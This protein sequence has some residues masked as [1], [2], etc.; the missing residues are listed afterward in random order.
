VTG[1]GLSETVIRWAATS[2]GL[3]SMTLTAAQSWAEEWVG[4]AVRTLSVFAVVDGPDGPA[5]GGTGDQRRRPAEQRSALWIID[6]YG[7]QVAFS[8]VTMGTIGD[9]IGPAQPESDGCRPT[10]WNHPPS[11]GSDRGKSRTANSNWAKTVKLEFSAL[12]E[13]VNR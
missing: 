5:P 6:I 7:C 10:E 13:A 12:Y 1:G 9:R 11:L 3:E 2:E 8:L 4:R